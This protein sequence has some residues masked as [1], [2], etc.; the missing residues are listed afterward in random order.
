M[1]DD[2]AQAIAEATAAGIDVTFSRPTRPDVGLTDL[3]IAVEGS[4]T[5]GDGR[6]SSRQILTRQEVDRHGDVAFAYAVHHVREA[7]QRAPARTARPSR[8]NP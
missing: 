3:E 8:S 2:L 1:T 5:T 6:L 4:R 7:I